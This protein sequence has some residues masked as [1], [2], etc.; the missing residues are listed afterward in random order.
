MYAEPSGIA[1]RVC[2]GIPANARAKGATSHAPVREPPRRPSVRRPRQ[3]HERPAAR[4]RS[5]RQRATNPARRWHSAAPRVRVRR[6]LVCPCQ[7]LGKA[8][9]FGALDLG[10]DAVAPELAYIMARYAA[11]A[12]QRTPPGVAVMNQ[13]QPRSWRVRS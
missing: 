1:P 7:G 9:S 6:L 4:V 11:L 12:P 2:A 8:K 3:D 10:H 5:A 13:S